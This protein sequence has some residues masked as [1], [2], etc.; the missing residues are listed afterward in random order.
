[1]IEGMDVAKLRLEESGSGWTMTLEPE[2]LGSGESARFT[3]VKPCEVEAWFLAEGPERIC[4][5]KGTV[6]MAIHDGREESSTR[7][8]ISSLYMGERTPRLV[9]VPAGV[10]YGYK[11]VGKSDAVLA[12]FSDDS[13]QGRTCPALP[14]DN[15]EIEY[16]WFSRKR[17]RL[18]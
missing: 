18:I 8:E 11:D 10:H 2:M 16:E 6:E 15:D 12:V 5:V 13:L 9:T 3:T 17:E 14:L 1:M 4:C 7:G